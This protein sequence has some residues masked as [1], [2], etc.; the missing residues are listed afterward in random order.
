MIPILFL[1][2][3]RVQAHNLTLNEFLLNKTLHDDDYILPLTTHGLVLEFSSPDHVVYD[4]EITTDITFQVLSPISSYMHNLHNNPFSRF[5]GV[6][7][8][9]E[10]RYLHKHVAGI[11]Q[12]WLNQI[13]GYE[14]FISDTHR[15]TRSVLQ[16]GLMMILGMYHVTKFL[17]SQR[18]ATEFD[19]HLTEMAD[20]LAQLATDNNN[21]LLQTTEILH[22]VQDYFCSTVDQFKTLHE[23]YAKSMVHNY[24]AQVHLTLQRAINNLLPNDPEAIQYLTSVCEDM[25]INH[26]RLCKFAALRGLKSVFKG[27]STSEDSFGSVRILINMAV[28][29]PIFSANQ[30]STK[31]SIGNLGYFNHTDRVALELPRTAYLF[32]INDT[33]H[34]TNSPVSLACSDFACPAASSILDLTPQKCLEGILLASPTDTERNCKIS[35]MTNHCSGIYVGNDQYFVNG[36]GLFTPSAELSPPITIAKPT[37][38]SSGVLTCKGKSIKFQANK[39]AGNIT[40]LLQN[41]SYLKVSTSSNFSELESITNRVEQLSFDINHTLITRSEDQ[42]YFSNLKNHISD[43]QTS[44]ESNFIVGLILS[45]LSI[46]LTILIYTL[47]K[48]LILIKRIQY[49]NAVNPIPPPRRDIRFDR[50]EEFP[51]DPI[52]TPSAR[53]INYKSKSLSNLSKKSK[54]NEVKKSIIVN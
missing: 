9:D 30:F 16:I 42:K 53:V 26:P 5:C 36:Q 39:K 49:K 12:L 38:V 33:I 54:A 31:I 29:I 21:I 23:Q 41:T 1:L 15:H 47:P 22:V 50:I 27:F 28:R 43:I 35:P 45:A 32:D 13:E 44:V 25:N 18:D 19:A 20:K 37:I 24:L 40:I 7:E 52:D 34:T 8:K 3:V 6:S 51:F 10:K 17:R 2:M 48:L 14:A 46:L 4:H 11:N